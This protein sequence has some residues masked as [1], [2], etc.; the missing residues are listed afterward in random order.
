MVANVN[1]MPTPKRI[2]PMPASKNPT[3]GIVNNCIKLMTMIT[4]PHTNIAIEVI[5]KDNHSTTTVTPTENK[6]AKTDIMRGNTT[7]NKNRPRTIS[8]IKFPLLFG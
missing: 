2:N 1:N 4:I 8:K 7:G 5:R 6:T 3:A